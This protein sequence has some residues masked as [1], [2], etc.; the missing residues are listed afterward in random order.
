MATLD[1]GKC[2]FW[3]EGNANFGRCRKAAPTVVG[4]LVRDDDFSPITARGVWPSTAETD[5]CGDGLPFD[6]E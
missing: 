6:D 3:D 5:W 1:C 2:Q 4:A